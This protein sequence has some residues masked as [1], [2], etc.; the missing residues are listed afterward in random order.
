MYTAASSVMH[1]PGKPQKVTCR[2]VVRKSCLWLHAL[3]AALCACVYGLSPCRRSA[4]EGYTFYLNQYMQ[5]SEDPQ[6][7]RLTH[8]HVAK[9]RLMDAPTFVEA[10]IQQ[11]PDTPERAQACLKYIQVCRGVLREAAGP[12]LH[13]PAMA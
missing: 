5:L 8:V 7:R 3:S 9:W 12:C 4:Y 1:S 6:G 2:G 11:P 13:T 10:W